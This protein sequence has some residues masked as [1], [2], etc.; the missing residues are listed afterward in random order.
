MLPVNITLAPRH[1]FKSTGKLP[2]WD[3]LML[4]GKAME[5]VFVSVSF[6][7]SWALKTTI[8]EARLW[9]ELSFSLPAKELFA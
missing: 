4:P 7:L 9:I 8:S 6:L 5:H 1:N 3:R 2:V